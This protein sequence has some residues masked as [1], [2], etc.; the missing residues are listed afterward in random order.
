MR[1]PHAKLG[2]IEMRVPSQIGGLTPFSASYA[3]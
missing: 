3:K 2:T 1:L